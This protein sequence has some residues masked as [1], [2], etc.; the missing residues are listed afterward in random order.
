MSAFNATGGCQCGRVR[1]A[2]TE[3]AQDLYH[4]HCSMCRKVHGAVFATYAIVPRSAFRVVSGENDI[5]GFESSPGVYR[6][7]CAAC[8]C[9]I[10]CEEAR[11]PAITFYAPGSLD[12]GCSPGHESARERHIYVGSKAPWFAISDGL[13]QSERD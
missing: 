6:Y 4:C 11:R 7:S 9:Q 2:V 12:D 8:G 5:R 10:Y 13:P 3:A 1:Y